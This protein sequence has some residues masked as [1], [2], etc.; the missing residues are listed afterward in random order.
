M[1]ALHERL[2]RLGLHE[3]LI[4]A[5]HAWAQ[6]TGYLDLQHHSDRGLRGRIEEFRQS[7]RGLDAARITLARPTVPLAP[8]SPATTGRSNP[9]GSVLEEGAARHRARLLAEQV[10][11]QVIAARLR[12]P[13]LREVC[14]KCSVGRACWEHEP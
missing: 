6:R 7:P 1:S 5:F 9:T 3:R 13:T 10:A 8:A 14:P 2:R 12:T 4:P 11:R